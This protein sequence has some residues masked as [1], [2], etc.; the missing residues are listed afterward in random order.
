MPSPSPQQL[1]VALR[2]GAL[3]V[4]YGAETWRV[5]DTVYRV[6]AAFGL[7]D[8]EVVATATSLM[9]TVRNGD[10]RETQVRRVRARHLDLAAIDTLNTLS[11]RAAAGQIDSAR[12]DAD[13]TAL[14]Q[15]GPLYSPTARAVG[16]LVGAAAFAAH[17][18]GGA[19]E[20]LL[21]LPGAAL[22]LVIQALLDKA[23]LP[24]LV[25]TVISALVGTIIAVN[26]STLVGLSSPRILVLVAVIRLV[27]GAAIVN[28]IGDLLGGHLLSGVARS[29][30][31]L[32]VATAIAVGVAIGLWVTDSPFTPI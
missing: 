30:A 23:R 9:A 1:D 15:R 6:L 3:L 26:I 22:L 17:F 28:A 11:R 13:L 25:A 19:A 31:A 2:V 8:S 21:S 29:V 12:L 32:L 10:Q 7:G 27:P 24:T 16:A 20:M 14:E 4:R 18:G 5:E